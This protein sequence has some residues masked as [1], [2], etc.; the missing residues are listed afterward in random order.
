MFHRFFQFSIVG[1]LAVVVIFSCP[2][3]AAAKPKVAVVMSRSIPP[4]RKALEGFKKRFESEVTIFEVHNKK[5][6]A[7]V[8]KTIMAGKPDIVLAIGSSALNLVS[9]HITKIPVVFTMVLTPPKLPSNIAGVSMMLPAKTHLE[10][11]KLVAPDVK[12]VGLVYN[13]KHSAKRI[14]EFKTAAK[15]LGLQIV[16]LAANSQKEAFSSIRLL[17]GRVDSLWMLMDKDVVANFNLMLSLS[18]KEKIPL[19]TFSYRYVEMGALLALSPKFDSLGQ[20]AGEIAVKIIAG[21]AP[22]SLGVISPKSHYYSYNTKTGLRIELGVPSAILK[23]EHRL[24]KK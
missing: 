20:Q 15:S 23:K 13:P 14:Q 12:S 22:S 18:V 1:L 9:K 7:K 19:A 2:A 11:L 10:G 17:A 8:A 4:Y 16:A 3:T 6:A 21:T 5:D 24:Y